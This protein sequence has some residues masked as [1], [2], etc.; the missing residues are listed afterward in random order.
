MRILSPNVSHSRWALKMGVLSITL[1]FALGTALCGPIV[2]DI[3]LLTLFTTART[4]YWL[5]PPQELAQT[6]GV[7]FLFELPT[8]LFFIMYTSVIH[9]WYLSL[10]SSSLVCPL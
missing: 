5:I 6:V 9:L 3:S 4:V 8:M 1:V 7:V 2:S 10:S